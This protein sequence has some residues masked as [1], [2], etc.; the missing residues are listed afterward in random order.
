MSNT[1]LTKV[2]KML[3]ILFN[4]YNN[5][6]TQIKPSYHRRFYDEFKMNLRFTGIV[7]KRGVGKTTFLLEYLRQNW[8]QSDQALYI[9]ADNLLF[10][11]HTLLELAAEF[12]RENDGRFLCIDEIHRY[13]NWNQEL[14]N[15]YD[16]YPQIQIIFSGSSSFNLIKGEYDF[17]RRAELI[18]M[19]GFSFR[20]YLETQTQ[21]KF[22]ILSLEDILQNSYQITAKLSQIPALIGKLHRYWKKG[23]YPTSLEIENLDSYWKSLVSLLNKTIFEDVASFYNIKTQNLESL[24]KLIYFFASSKPGKLN[25]NKL[26][27]SLNKGHIT[28][29]KYIQMLRD[30]SL[31]CFLSNDKLGHALVRNAEKIYLSDTNLLWAINAQLGNDPELGAVREIFVLNQLKSAGYLATYPKKGKGD[32]V[33]GDWTFEI[34]GKNKTQKQIKGLPKAKLVLD[35]ILVSSKNSLSL[36]LFGFLY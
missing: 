19:P 1:L 26:A 7:G 17:S 24:R 2:K 27:K 28:I 34:G 36:Y 16:T 23:F 3:N 18:N 30:T 29:A 4:D 21:Q 32:L 25:I 8:F 9:S 12:V 35:N 15:I 14:K 33:V 20:E 6:L 11:G 31:L 5:L 13:A 10:A 22:P